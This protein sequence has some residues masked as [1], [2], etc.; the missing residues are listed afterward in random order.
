MLAYV[1]LLNAGC[2]GNPGLRRECIF[3]DH[4][5]F[6]KRD[7]WLLSY[8]WLPWAILL[9]S[10]NHLEPHPTLNT[11]CSNC[12]P[13][14]HPVLSIEFYPADHFRERQDSFGWKGILDN[15]GLLCAICYDNETW[16]SNSW[17][18]SS[19]GGKDPMD[20]QHGRVVIL[21]KQFIYRFGGKLACFICS[22]DIIT[23]IWVWKKLNH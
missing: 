16:H 6:D 10:S 15:N 11:H 9:D 12:M 8:L 19:S 4:S 20:T 13:P 7:E 1:L 3:G 2:F 5:L 18:T 17:S 22:F 21:L 23:G 14:H